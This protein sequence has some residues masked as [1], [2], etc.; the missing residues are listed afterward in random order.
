MQ[1]DSVEQI[2]GMAGCDCVVVGRRYMFGWVF[3]CWEF[4][5]HL[6]GL[7]VG[8]SWGMVKVGFNID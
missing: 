1:S 3:V 8:R 2:R 5:F 7:G 4:G 6:G